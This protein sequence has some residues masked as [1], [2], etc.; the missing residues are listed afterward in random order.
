MDTFVECEGDGDASGNVLFYNK[1]LTLYYCYSIVLEREEKRYSN[2]IWQ[3][4]YG[5]HYKS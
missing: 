5:S 4:T 1:L 2:Q 3:V